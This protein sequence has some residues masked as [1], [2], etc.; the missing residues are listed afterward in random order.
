MKVSEW[1]SLFD[2]TFM[3]EAFGKKMALPSL[4]KNFKK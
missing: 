3:T 2:K 1:F 4:D